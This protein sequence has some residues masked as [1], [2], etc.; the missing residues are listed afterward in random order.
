MGSREPRTLHLSTASVLAQT[1]WSA[2][3]C[4]LGFVT[5][6]SDS[7]IKIVKWTPGG[8]FSIH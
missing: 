7:V 3:G 5:S 4:V 2:G 6:L 8:S 1:A